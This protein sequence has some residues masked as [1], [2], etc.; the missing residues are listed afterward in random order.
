M[1]GGRSGVI[2]VAAAGVTVI[3]T[4]VLNTLNPALFYRIGASGRRQLRQGRRFA[5]A[6]ASQ[7]TDLRRAAGFFIEPNLTAL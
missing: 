4:T 7:L 3:G 5:T 6:G 2:A 1:A